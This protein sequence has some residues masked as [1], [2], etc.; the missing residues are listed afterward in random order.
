MNISPW[1]CNHLKK[2]KCWKSFFLTLESVRSS[3]GFVILKLIDVDVFVCWLCVSSGGTLHTKIPVTTHSALWDSATVALRLWKRWTWH[4]WN[5][6]LE[7]PKL[8]LS[9]GRSV[10]IFTES[11][12]HDKYDDILHDLLRNI[13][14]EHKETCMLVVKNMKRNVCLSGEIPQ[15]KELGAM[16]AVYRALLSQILFYC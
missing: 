9:H 7:C 3:L 6:D 13:E 8:L 5:S 16:C 4:F 10:Q 15:K 1:S 12:L 14:H 2:K 11:L